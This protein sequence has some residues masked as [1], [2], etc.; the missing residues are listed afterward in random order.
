MARAV[1]EALRPGD[2]VLELACVTGTLTFEAAKVANKVVDVDI[3]SN[4]VNVAKQKPE[5]DGRK[6]LSVRAV[7]V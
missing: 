4:M 3:S 1:E 6:G 7:K 2:M 5:F